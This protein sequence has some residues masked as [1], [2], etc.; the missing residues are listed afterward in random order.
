MR[1]RGTLFTLRWT[2]ALFAS[3][4]LGWLAACGDKGGGGDGDG[5]AALADGDVGDAEPVDA[6][7]VDGVIVTDPDG[8]VRECFVA[9]CPGR[10]QPLACGDCI[11]ND[12]DG[13]VD[14]R[15]PECLGPCDNTEGP[16]LEPG[17]GGVG[18]ATCKADCF[19]DF[20]SG[21]GND[22]CQWDY[23]CDP[24]GPR[25]MQGGS[26]FGGACQPIQQSGGG[27][28]APSQATCD[29]YFAGT[30]ASIGTCRNACLP[31]TPNACDCFGCCTFQNAQPTGQPD[32]PRNIYIGAFVGNSGSCT[33]ADIRDPGKCPT[34]TP[35]PSCLN[36]CETCEVCI[37]HPPPP[38]SCTPEE[39]C[40]GGEQAC[41]L[42]G[43]ADCPPGSFC[44]T[45]CCQDGIP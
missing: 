14:D 38:P 24:L 19:F 20:G 28:G 34:C 18:S 27:G 21:A 13:H 43:Q 22:A 23:R 16:A 35:V 12:G 8:G 9:L 44:I 31:L 11:D 42:S 33:F 37:G 4:S 30:Y 17:V 6:D 25:W 26:S 45:G 36:P 5:D 1:D 10:N 40:P 41:G 29:S 39:Q 3:L 7:D 2:L 32:G 15:D